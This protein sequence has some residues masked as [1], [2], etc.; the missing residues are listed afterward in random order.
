M[1]WETRLVALS[2]LA[3]GAVAMVGIRGTRWLVL[4]AILSNSFQ[5]LWLTTEHKGLPSEGT[6]LER[7]RT[8]QTSAFVRWWLWNMNYH[9]EHHAWPA[10]PWHCL[11][12]VHRQVVGYLDHVATGYGRL[13]LKVL[14]RRN[15]PDG[16]IRLEQNPCPRS[17]RRFLSK[18]P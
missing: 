10:V 4:A 13:Q 15:L 14:W 7:T 8:L 5:A 18:L 2:W 17:K 16:V 1:A 11:P 3:V 12:A 9:A 6:I